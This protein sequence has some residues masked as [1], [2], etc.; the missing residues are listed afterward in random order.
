MIKH[1][2]SSVWGQANSEQRRRRLSRRT[3]LKH[4][5]QRGMNSGIPMNLC[6]C[7]EPTTHIV[8]PRASAVF[9]PHR[10][11]TPHDLTRMGRERS[12]RCIS[13]TV[14]SARPLL[15]RDPKTIAST[16]PSHIYR[17]VSNT[18]APL[19]LPHHQ[20]HISTAVASTSLHLKRYIPEVTPQ[21]LRL[22]IPVTSPQD[23]YMC[24]TGASQLSLC[25]L[26]DVF[27]PYL[28]LL[29][30]RNLVSTR[31]SHVPAAATHPPPPF[32]PNG[33]VF[34]TFPPCHHTPNTVKSPL[35]LFLHHRRISSTATV[36]PQRTWDREKK[37]SW[38][39]LLGGDTV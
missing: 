28:L 29:H 16:P 38:I 12:G 33:C 23:G 4:A 17:D 25:F 3:C 27:I 31:R 30:K 20:M 22:Y 5:S 15:H 37:E 21:T 24:T 1:F 13:A 18:V 34:T 11:S 19:P 9:S 8:L 32:H 35:L 14:V 7:E 10:P 26:R 6:P 39:H 2:N 36:P